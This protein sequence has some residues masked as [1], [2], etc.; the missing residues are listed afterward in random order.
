MHSHEPFRSTTSEVGTNTGREARLSEQHVPR[1]DI[2]ISEGVAFPA[3][4]YRAEIEPLLNFYQAVYVGRVAELAG[5]IQFTTKQVPG[6]LIITA[7]PGYGKSALVAATIRHFERQNLDNQGTIP[8]VIFFFIREGDHHN[9]SSDFLIAV[10]SQLIS[11]L[12]VS[13]EVPADRRAL[14]GQFI[15]L[16]A[17]AVERACASQ[18]LLLIVDGLDEA[19]DDSSDISNCLPTRM[20]SHVHVVVTSRPNPDPRARVAPEHPLRRATAW[21]LASF[22]VADIQQLLAA[23]GAGTAS[24]ELARRI[25]ELTGGEPLLARFTTEDVAQGG[26]GALD[27]VELVRPQGAREYFAWQLNQ[28]DTRLTRNS[29]VEALRVARQVLGLLLAAHG[30]MTQIELSEA[31]KVPLFEIRRAVSVIV[32]FLLGSDRLQLMHQEL[33]TL[34]K[35]TY[36]STSELMSYSNR[37]R[38]WCLE[39]ETLGWPPTTPE[40]IVDHCASHFADI[41]D[42]DTLSRLVGRAWQRLRYKRTRSHRGFAED[43]R[44]ALKTIAESTPANIASELRCSLTRCTV[45]SMTAWIRQLCWSA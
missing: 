37:L 26:E 6:Y 4:D 11:L 29:Q 13:E 30:P 24:L 44:L 36:F 20:G 25:L 7:P 15:R 8:D 14:S 43:V 31:L 34:L 22:G 45:G 19:S 10:N 21:N 41:K 35:E 23:Q 18:P 38:S 1:R 32:R 33:R 39:F 42:S 2:Q 3:P 9:K 12:R 16:W 28:L 40:Y 5:L 17:D 27:I